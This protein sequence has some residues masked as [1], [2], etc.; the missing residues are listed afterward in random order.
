M[1]KGAKPPPDPPPPIPPV[2]SDNPAGDA[3]AAILRR[4]AAREGTNYE[5]TILG[6]GS[7]SAGSNT[8]LGR[9]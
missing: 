5:D 8:L 6:G 2:V 4:K 3:D 7:L 1:G 9:G